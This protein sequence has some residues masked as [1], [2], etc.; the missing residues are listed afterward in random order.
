M[1][2]AVEIELLGKIY[3]VNCPVGQEEILRNAKGRVE[4]KM[5]DLRG[6]AKVAN[7]EKLAVITALNLSYQLGE[8]LQRNNEY[9]QE[10]EIKIKALNEKVNVALLDHE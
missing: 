3:H 1:A 7:M 5:L 8:E 4:E 10:L 2:N 9:T 6:K